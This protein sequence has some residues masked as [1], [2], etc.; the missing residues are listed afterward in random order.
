MTAV[1]S[2]KNPEMSSST[3]NADNNVFPIDIA[4]QGDD[5]AVYVKQ[6]GVSV[7]HMHVRTW[8]HRQEHSVHSV[9]EHHRQQQRGHMKHTQ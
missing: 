1:K 8:L 9:R 6:N 3:L 7:V 5:N 2:V 4:T